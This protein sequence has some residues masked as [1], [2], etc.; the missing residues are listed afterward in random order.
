MEN[1]SKALLIAGAI[2]IAILLIA[3]GMMVFNSANSTIKT[4]TSN[5]SQQ[6]KTAFNQQFSVYEGTKS[7][8][9]TKQLIELI[10]TNNSVDENSKITVS[11]G[12]G[13]TVTDKGVV[14]G[15]DGLKNQAQ[16]K[17]DFDDT[18]NDGVIETCTINTAGS[19]PSK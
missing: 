19:T 4:A 5:M 13:V 7:G 3:I 9:V 16:Y 11:G 1:A 2:L 18:D 10:A 8:S 12:A 17:I 14:N 15:K 6:D